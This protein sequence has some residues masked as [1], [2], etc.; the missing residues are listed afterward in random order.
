MYVSGYE[1]KHIDPADVRSF[2]YIFDR[3]GATGP[4]KAPGND[5]VWQG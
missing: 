5:Y 3:Y 4:L 1:I 2:T